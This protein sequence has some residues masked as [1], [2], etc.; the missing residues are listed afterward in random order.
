MKRKVLA[1]LVSLAMLL[2]FSTAVSAKQEIAQLQSTNVILPGD[3]GPVS[4]LGG[5]SF[6]TYTGQ[7]KLVVKGNYRGG[8]AY[9]YRPEFYL[10]VYKVTNGNYERVGGYQEMGYSGVNN[11][12]FF[13]LPNLPYGTYEVL[14]GGGL[15]Y[16]AS[17]EN[18]YFT[19]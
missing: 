7:G 3:S 9:G 5:T 4:G 13:S 1:M 12:I 10:S 19:P 17:N 14:I 2:T 18:V 8:N 6:G 15:V 16:G 11:S